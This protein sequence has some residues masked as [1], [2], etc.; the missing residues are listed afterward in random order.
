MKAPTDQAQAIS[1]GEMTRERKAQ[2]SAGAPANQCRPLHML[3]FFSIRLIL[4]GVFIFA[5]LDKIMHPL[6]FAKSISNYQILPDQLINL[7]A[8]ILPWLELVLGTLPVSGVRLPGTIVLI[9]LLLVVFFIAL[10]VNLAR[11][12]NVDCGCFSTGPT[13]NPATSWYIIR[14][15]LL[16]LLGG[17]LWQRSLIRLF[18]P[19]TRKAVPEISNLWKIGR[20]HADFSG[21]FSFWCNDPVAQ[22]GQMRPRQVCPCDCYLTLPQMFFV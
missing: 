8:I 4:G 20:C 13:E 21:R 19:L 7:A 12:L 5:S 14:D 18:P 11:G 22:M 1:Q 17:Y 16:L 10:L 2:A 15:T 6:G 3:L 9:D